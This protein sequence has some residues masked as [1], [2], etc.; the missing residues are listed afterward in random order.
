[1][2]LSAFSGDANLGI[3]ECAGC[4]DAVS[5]DKSPEGAGSSEARVAAPS[6]TGV[7]IDP[8][9]STARGSVDSAGGELLADASEAVSVGASEGDCAGGVSAG[10][11][12][13][14]MGFFAVSRRPVANSMTWP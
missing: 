10:F 5:G 14:I 7:S 13:L 6:A 3:R 4:S 8:V 1:M 2:I 9:L 11:A 12:G